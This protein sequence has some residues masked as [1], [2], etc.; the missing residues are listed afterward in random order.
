M[1][2]SDLWPGPVY[3]CRKP[4]EAG[5][6]SLTINRVGQAEDHVNL[7][8]F[9]H[10]M[11]GCNS[12]SALEIL[13]AP[14]I[15]FMADEEAPTHKSDSHVSMLNAPSMPTR[16][17][18][19]NQRVS[20][21][22]QKGALRTVPCFECSQRSRGCHQQ[23]AWTTRR[24]AACFECR[25]LKLPC[26]LVGMTHSFRT[27]NILPHLV[28]TVRRPPAITITHQSPG[29]PPRDESDRAVGSGPYPCREGWHPR[30]P[31]LREMH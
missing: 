28:G 20:P 2:R 6:P 16:Q 26:S 23:L 18:R 31:I 13:S 3:Q 5:T 4:R 15:A 1:P 11:Q 8:P 30:A 22:F 10:T 29:G 21:G 7:F 24:S 19:S 27:K 9:F 25:R 14:P 17:T 12:P